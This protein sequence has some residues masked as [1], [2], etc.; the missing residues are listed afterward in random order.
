MTT[1]IIEK[2][3][4]ENG[5]EENNYPYVC[6]FMISGDKPILHDRIILKPNNES[7]GE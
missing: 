7:E 5:I 3:N 4:L 6:G 2:D 1:T